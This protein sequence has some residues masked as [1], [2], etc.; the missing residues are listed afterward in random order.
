M[1][2]IQS[3]STDNFLG[4]AVKRSSSRKSSSASV[5]GRDD[6]SSVVDETSERYSRKNVRTVKLISTLMIWLKNINKMRAMMTSKGFYKWR[7]TASTMTILAHRPLISLTPSP[8]PAVSASPIKNDASEET[9]ARLIEMKNNYLAM[10][11]ENEKL[12]DQLSEVRRQHSSIDTQM[13]LQAGKLVIQGVVKRR[14]YMKLR[15]A[16][17]TWTS[18][19]AI[20]RLVAD[21]SHQAMELAVGLQQ[22]ESERTYVRQTEHANTRLRM[23]LTLT[24]YFF[25]WKSKASAIVLAQERKVHEEQRRVIFQELRRMREVV[26]YAN[27]QEQL[28]MQGAVKRGDEADSHITVVKERIERIVTASRQYKAQLP[29]DIENVIKRVAISAHGGGV[30]QSREE[31]GRGE[32][33]RTPDRVGGKSRKQQSITHIQSG[34]IAMFQQQ[35]QPQHE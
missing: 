34:T 35:Q 19:T 5:V 2:D 18:S 23:L 8:L 31:G 15:Y 33:K 14:L 1:S 24:I 3:S 29:E 21:T 6:C 4:K 11:A 16:F 13:R 30:A 7:Y 27:D 25:K 12:R 22:V 28:L 26:S 17:D 32:G 20:H 9:E 10:F